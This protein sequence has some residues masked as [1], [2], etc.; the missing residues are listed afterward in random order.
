M[1]TK[2]GFTNDEFLR[3]LNDLR[4]AGRSADE[5]LEEAMYYDEGQHAANK[6][7]QEYESYDDNMDFAD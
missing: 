3:M 6:A 1:P 2:R 5:A 7:L 4:G